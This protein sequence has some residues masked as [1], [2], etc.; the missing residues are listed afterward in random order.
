MVVR[1]GRFL[2]YW[3]VETG[4]IIPVCAFLAFTG[5]LIWGWWHDKQT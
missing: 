1:L 4:Y 3:L 5:P 2:G